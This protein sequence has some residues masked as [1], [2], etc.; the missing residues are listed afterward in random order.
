MSETSTVG[1]LADLIDSLPDATPIVVRSQGECNRVDV[2]VDGDA[3]IFE[4]F[5]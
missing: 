3:L 1:E 4:G 5:N 2:Y